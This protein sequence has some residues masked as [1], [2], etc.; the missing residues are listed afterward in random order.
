V[1][2]RLAFSTLFEEELNEN[3]APAVRAWA[4]TVFGGP[5]MEVDE[6]MFTVSPDSMALTNGRALGVLASRAPRWI[7]DCRLHG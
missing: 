4:D 1:R 5:N 2:I 6:A 3:D 7:F